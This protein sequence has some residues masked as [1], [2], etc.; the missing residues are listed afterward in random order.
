MQIRIVTIG[1][2]KSNQIKEI[3][4]EFIKRLTASPFKVTHVEI[5]N[6]KLA[7]KDIE[8]TKR[9]EA[10]ELL[11]QFKNGEVLVALDESGKQFSSVKFSAWLQTKMN[12]GVKVI[13]FAIGGAYG[14]HESVRKKADLVFSLSELTFPYQFAR[15]LLIEQIYRAASLLNGSSY[16]KE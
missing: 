3:E 12:S 11:A 4:A 13:V 1:K 8:E 6:S 10:I 9:L 7:K 16:H 14:F 2:L 5:N 15:L